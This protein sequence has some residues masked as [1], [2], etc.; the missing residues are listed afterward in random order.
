MQPGRDGFRRHHELIGA[1]S[2]E[3]VVDTIGRADIAVFRPST[4]TWYTIGS[5]AGITVTN[6]GQQGD[7]PV[8]SVFNY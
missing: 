3:G 4:G 7:T 5:T 1:G 6:F 2:E 8:P